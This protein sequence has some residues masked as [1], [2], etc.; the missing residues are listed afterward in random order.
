[1]Y[2]TGTIGYLNYSC[3]CDQDGN[4]MNY[5]SGCMLHNRKTGYFKRLSVRLIKIILL[6]YINA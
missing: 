6:R 4:N 1:M 2:E 3:E 5:S